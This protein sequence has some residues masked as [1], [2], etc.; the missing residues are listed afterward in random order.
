MPRA[1]G[2]VPRLRRRAR[3]SEPPRARRRASLSEATLGLVVGLGPAVEPPIDPVV[4]GPAGLTLRWE[5]PAGCPDR[6]QVRDLVEA[7]LGEVDEADEGG[8]RAVDV[9]GRLEAHPPEGY[10]LVLELNDGR[11]GTR[12]LQGPSCRELSE[13]AAL[14]I[15]MAIDPRLLERGPGTPEGPSEVPGAPETPGEVPD[16]PEAVELGAPTEA[17]AVEEVE[18]ARIEEVE[19]TPV[20]PPAPPVPRRRPSFVGRLEAG[21]GGGPLPGLSGVFGAMV[22]VGGRA[23]RAEL[24]ASYWTPR[25]ATSSGNPDVGARAQLW[26]VAMQGC[27]EPRWRM[28]SFPSCVGLLAGAVQARGVGALPATR[29]TTRWVAAAVEPGLV[30]WVGSH[31]GLGIRARGHAAL[32]R[33]ELRSEPSGTIFV[34]SPVGGSLRVGVELRWP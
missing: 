34:G 33:P 26:A 2:L 6:A 11:A 14:V 21:V 25:T 20:P 29:I 32:A 15:A 5:A 31:W 3:S 7:T 23:W 9:G 28:L 13:A 18:S 4:E 12:E 1:L 10:R 24:G 27:G 30:W 17:E 8:R 16:T 19:P 22:G